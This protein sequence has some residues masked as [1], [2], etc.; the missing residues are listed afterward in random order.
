MYLLNENHAKKSIKR[1]SIMNLIIHKLNLTH[2]WSKIWMCDYKTII[3]N[4]EC[5]VI[6]SQLKSI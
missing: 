6:D 5:I 3:S 2:Y 4:N 1:K